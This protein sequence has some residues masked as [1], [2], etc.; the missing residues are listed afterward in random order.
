[1]IGRLVQTVAVVA[2]LTQPAIGCSLDPSADL[3]TLAELIL[4]SRN[5]FVG[6][7][8]AYVTGDGEEISDLAPYTTT[9]R[10]C[11]TTAATK[12]K[13]N[14]PAAEPNP[15]EVPTAS[16]T[17]PPTGCEE[18]TSL[19]IR[20]DSVVFQVEARYRG[21]DESRLVV[22]QGGGGDCGVTFELGKRYFYSGS[23]ILDPTREVDADVPAATILRDTLAAAG[24]SVD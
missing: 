6:T 12:N 5:V 22:R 2:A 18:Y 8:V 9:Y 11:P 15:T 10:R 21:P 4:D 19:D 14:S 16:P 24:I 23:F 13:K 7:V 20:V 3:P 17:F 1:M